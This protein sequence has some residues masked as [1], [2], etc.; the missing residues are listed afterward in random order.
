MLSKQ[1][2]I[3]LLAWYRENARLLPWREDPTP[4]AVYVSE[5][6]LQQTRVEAVKGYYL[7][8][9]DELPDIRSLADAPE[10]LLL[11][12]WEGLG[13]Y[14]RVRNMKKTA[15]ILVRE[16]N[17][18]FPPTE[19]ELLALPGI[20]PYTAA[21]V[22]SIAFGKK[23]AA[24]DGNVLRVYTRLAADPTRI[25]DLSFRKKIKQEMEDQ[26]PEETAVFTQA[27][28]ELGAMVCV[29]KN[30]R[31]GIC[32]VQAF[33][34]GYRDGNP[35]QYPVRSGKKEKKKE[36]KT[37][38]LL[39]HAQHIA[40]HKRAEKGMLS[41]L[42]ELPNTEGHLSAQEACRYLEA[43]GIPAVTVRQGIPY[44]HIFTHREWD[45]VSYVVET[46]EESPLYFWVTD[47]ELAESY[48][49]PTAFSMFL[50]RETESV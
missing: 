2:M 1:M 13:Y 16:Y 6:M 12:L 42:W 35:E 36:E 26:M 41:G 32:P 22:A 33:C 31:C 8:F 3:P 45:M 14:S 27:W 15:Q 11:K 46:G 28:M 39:C 44:T 10:D 48:A 9:M 49:L 23:A 17:G 50:S 37:V 19:K 38:F 20:G 21:A 47:E 29:P 34:K 25:D 18:Q 24:V 40:I 5:I 7:R 4:Y 43:Q 30:P